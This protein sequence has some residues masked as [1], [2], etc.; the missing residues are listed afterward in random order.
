MQ[1]NR[2]MRT[3]A[4]VLTAER[5]FNPFSFAQRHIGPQADEVRRMLQVVG[6]PNLEALIDEAMPADG[7]ATRYRASAVRSRTIGK[8][9]RGRLP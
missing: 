9:A 5:A 3:S 2:L 1:S 4:E 7:S 8:N 6:V